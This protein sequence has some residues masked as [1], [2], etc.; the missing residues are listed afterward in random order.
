MGSISKI[1]FLA[2]VYSLQAKQTTFWE[3]SLSSIQAVLTSLFPDVNN[4]GLGLPTEVECA[5]SPTTHRT[6]GSWV[7][8]QALQ[9]TTIRP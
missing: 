2:S 3:S 4:G 8:H 9:S 1:F 7:G 5:N 6:Q